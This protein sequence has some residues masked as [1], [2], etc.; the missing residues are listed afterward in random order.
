LP[1]FSSPCS[2]V[3]LEDDDEEEK[4]DDFNIRVHPW[5]IYSL[6]DFYGG[7]GLNSAFRIFFSTFPSK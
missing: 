6:S 4:G 2:L 1:S 3:G 5:F 7:F